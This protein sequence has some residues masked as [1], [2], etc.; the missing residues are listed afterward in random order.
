MTVDIQKL[1]ALAEAATQGEWTCKDKPD[2]RFWHIGCGS[3]AIGSTYAASKKHSPDVA[4]MF[5]ANAKFIV[6][7]NPSA[8]LELITEIQRLRQFEVAYKEYSD[9][10]DWVQE[11]A[12]WSELGMHRA[13]VLRKRCDDAASQLQAQA[14][15]L[16]KLMAENEAL[17]K[18]GP[19][20]EI[21]WCACGDGYPENSYGAGFMDANNGVCQN[22]DAANIT[23]KQST[24]AQIAA[25]LGRHSQEAE[26][27]RCAL[28]REG[29]IAAQ[30]ECDRIAGDSAG[31]TDRERKGAGEC[32]A[33]IRAL[34]EGLSKGHQ[35][36]G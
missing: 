6:A 11:N 18:H 8:V 12:H 1:K 22:C 19:S 9:K 27:S 35:A 15:Q 34:I 23:A 30:K 3:Q 26:A 33:A 28:R 16:K 4:A 2:G 13:D 7:A 31:R 10:T 32:S 24:S 21:I 20:T 25:A 17:R 14:D 36:H 29:M 5:E